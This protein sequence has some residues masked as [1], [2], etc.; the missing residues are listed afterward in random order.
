[1]LWAFDLSERMGWA[2]GSHPGTWLRGLPGGGQA[3]AAAG[4][5]GWEASE[6]PAD[7]EMAEVTQAGTAGCC[8]LCGCWQGSSAP[9]ARSRL[10][11]RLPRPTPASRQQG[12]LDVGDYERA[13]L[14]LGCVGAPYEVWSSSEGE[15]PAGWR[16]P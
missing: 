8:L 5:G 1:M 15:A 14:P 3:A 9:G 6:G 10:V 7:A 12:Y 2:D 11:P 4:D 13:P 16:R